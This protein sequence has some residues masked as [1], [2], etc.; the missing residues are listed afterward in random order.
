MN[1]TLYQLSHNYVQA[2]DF[3]TDPE[4]DVP[5][6]VINDTLEGLAGGLEDKA[7]NVAKFLRNLESTAEAIKAAEAAMAKRRKALENRTGWLKGYLK[8]SM[9]NTGISQIDCPYFRLS[10][11]KNPAALEITDEQAIPQHFKHTETLTVVQI[12]K[13]AV[14]AA[15]AQGKAIPGA[16]LSQG[17]RLSIR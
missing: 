5:L 10:I 3:L 7:I 14:K 13:A 12:D 16:R 2:L 9:E 1:L 8:A 4:A 11:A 6:T 15:L 17:T